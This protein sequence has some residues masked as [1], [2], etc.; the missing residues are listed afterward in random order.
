VLVS[1]LYL[2]VLRCR[3]GLCMQVLTL[4]VQNTA[5]YR[6]LGVATSG[7][8]FFRTMGSSFGAAIFGSNLR[9]QLAG[10]LAVA[11][12][13]TPRVDQRRAEQ[14]GRGTQPAGRPGRGR[15]SGYSETVQTLFRAGVPSPWWPRCSAVPEAGPLRGVAKAG[16]N[17]VGDG[18]AMPEARSSRDRLEVAHRAADAA[19]GPWCR[20]GHPGR[21][22]HLAR[23]G[24]GLV[25]ESGARALQVT[26]RATLT[27]I[28]S[29]CMCRVRCLWPGVR[30]DHLGR[31]PA[32]RR[33]AALAHRGRGPGRAKVTDSFLAWLSAHLSGWAATARP[34][35]AELMTGWAGGP[36][37]FLVEGRL[38][39]APRAGRTTSR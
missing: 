24:R 27:D 25:R 12:A 35:H 9:N 2:L 22:A 36:R 19:A 20:A 7:V 14:P 38:R 10:H 1:S 29:T 21:R 18:F 13:A 11:L 34:S 39:R 17:D 32:I 33:R 8:T 16:A 15:S 37:R 26:G 30:P 4:I 3:I 23:P 28:A 5:D 31:I 6:D